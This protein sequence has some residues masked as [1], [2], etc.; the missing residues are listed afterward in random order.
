[1]T[2]MTELEE[3]GG[4]RIKHITMKE[5]TKIAKRG[6]R[7]AHK[8]E[9]NRTSR[10]MRKMKHNECRIIR[11]RNKGGHKNKKK[12]TQTNNTMNYNHTKK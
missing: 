9:N 7:G 3:C 11:T 5:T 8:R 12:K 10:I 2:S 4:R 6:R 1:M